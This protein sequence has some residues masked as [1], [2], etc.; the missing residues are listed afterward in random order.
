MRLTMLMLI[1]A[2]IIAGCGGPP[3]A[4]KKGPVE[5]IFWHGM[6]GPLG[7]ALKEMINQFNRANPEIVVK[8]VH[9]GQYDTLQQ[10]IIASLVAGTSP[11]LAQCY[12]A[13]TMKLISA[14]KIIPLNQFIDQQLDFRKED[15]FPSFLANNTYDGVIY[16]MPFNKSTPVMYYN[17][18]LFRKY[19]LDPEKPPATW[20]ELFEA[21][22]KLTVDTNGDGKPDQWGQ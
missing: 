10:K 8:E 17:K 11:D 16:S 19:G 5:I 20:D 18:D 12:E 1:L 15:I 14:G 21:S 3:E 13:L 6:G 4:V 9:M 2:I 7:D 22:K